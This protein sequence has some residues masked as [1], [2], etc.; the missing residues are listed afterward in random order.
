MEKDQVRETQKTMLAAWW[1]SQS[2]WK[3]RQDMASEI[4][5]N[6]STLGDY[7]GGRA[8]PTGERRRTM[9]Q[10]TE[11]SC[12]APDNG[13]PDEKPDAKPIPQVPRVPHV[14]QAPPFD[15]SR[16]LFAAAEQVLGS[17]ITS[18][19]SKALQDA[20]ALEL[21]GAYREI[22]RQLAALNESVT[23]V[24]TAVDVLTARPVQ[25]AL[26]PQPEEQME[27]PVRGAKQDVPPQQIII[28]LPDMP[29][30]KVADEG[31][32]RT[33]QRL[34]ELA[35]LLAEYASLP[36]EHPKR[37]EMRQAL[38]QPVHQLFPVLI[39]FERQYPS[40]FTKELEGY[41]EIINLN[42]GGGVYG[43]R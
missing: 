39:A 18:A 29:N 38:L 21:L 7:F 20:P 8:I 5:I 13:K 35:K 28:R 19:V 34:L 33:R 15:V 12:F 11:L 37:E 25:A 32:Q 14:P 1:T 22:A 41:R 43:N 42:L 10:A 36:E 27:T 23:R 30:V 4:G 9:Y 17:V 16:L 3:Q 40:D 31:M 26:L 2:R 6:R 24:S